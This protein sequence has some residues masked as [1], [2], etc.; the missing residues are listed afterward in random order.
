MSCT[1]RRNTNVRPRRTGYVYVSNVRPLRTGYVQVS[2]KS[3]MRSVV[4]TFSAPTKDTYSE[5]VKSDVPDITKK[6]EMDTST[7]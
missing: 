7:N 4:V 5:Q 2:G 1:S 6:K 3:Q